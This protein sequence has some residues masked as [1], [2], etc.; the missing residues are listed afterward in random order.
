MKQQPV[1]A[2]FLTGLGF[3]EGPRWH[4]GCLWFSDIVQRKVMR[5]T[6][7]GE[8]TTVLET[9]G[10]PSGLGW[11]SDGTLLVV[12]MAEHDVLRWRDG[13]LQHHSHTA[14]LSRAK[15]NDMVVD[16]RGRAWVSNLGFDYEKEE[17]RTTN[18]VFI[19][20][21]GAPAVAAADIHCPNGMAL[22]D[23]GDRLY[24]GQSA[25]REV[26]EFRVAADGS[27]HD[28]QV[29]ATL[30]RGCMSDG[31]CLDAA[32]GLWIASP[33]SREFLRVERGGHISHRIGTGQRHAIAC[34]LG[35]ADRRTLYCATAATMSLQ[36]A[37]H[38]RDG[39][40]ETAQVEVPGAGIP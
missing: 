3:A 33:V 11:L 16:R 25:A 36:V 9:P 21:D 4:D 6:P 29:F 2:P 10:E 22:N 32:D 26:L 38:N 39:R 34:V 15:L 37:H 23:A 13:S 1:L 31:V 5:A 14:P 20:R 28:R 35:G 19:D 8:L 40:I 12:M 24:V 7:H 18:I 17:P 27:L 30:P